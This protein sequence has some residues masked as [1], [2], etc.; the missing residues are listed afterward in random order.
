MKAFHPDFLTQG[1]FI[2][3]IG[4]ILV[5][6]SKKRTLLV[7]IALFELGSLLCAVSRSL[8][9]LIFGRAVA[10]CGASGYIFSQFCL[11]LILNDACPTEFRI[12][13]SVTT[14]IPEVSDITILCFL[15]MNSF[16]YPRLR[17]LNCVRYCLLSLEQYSEF[18]PLWGRY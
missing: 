6:A 5:L 10:G 16:A 12:Q 13:M 4:Q 15:P 7:S 14:A 17:P 2:L 8:P 9:V 1:G 3:F 18:H 11:E